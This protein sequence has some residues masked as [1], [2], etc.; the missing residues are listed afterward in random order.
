MKED[1]IIALTVVVCFIIVAATFCYCVNDTN[2]ANVKIAEV[3]K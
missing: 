1:S 2:T 3:K